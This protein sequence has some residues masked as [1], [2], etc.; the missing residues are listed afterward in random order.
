MLF[1]KAQLERLH[2]A[3]QQESGFPWVETIV[4]RYDRHC[5]AGFSEFEL[6]G[7]FVTEKVQRPWLQKRLPYKKMA[8]YATLQQR[9]Q[10]QRWSLTFPDYMRQNQQG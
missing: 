3:L 8:D 7:N 10:S 2:E 4:K 6:Y 1:D 5:E 9:Y